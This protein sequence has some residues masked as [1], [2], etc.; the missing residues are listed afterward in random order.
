M[1]TVDVVLPTPPFWLATVMTRMRPGAGKGSWSAACST[2]VARRASIAMGLSKS[3]IPKEDAD[4]WSAARLLRSRSPGSV[5]ASP[6]S[7]AAFHVERVG[8]ILL[9]HVEQ[10]PDWSRR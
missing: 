3:A 5:I 7:A 2:R 4:D 1:F 10:A 9:F 6:S 8:H